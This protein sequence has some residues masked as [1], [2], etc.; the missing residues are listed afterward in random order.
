M[1]II[2]ASFGRTAT[3]STRIA[4]NHLGFG[5][6]YHMI[7]VFMHPSHIAQWQAAADGHPVDWREFLA[8]YP[9]GL[10]YPFSAFYKE[11]LAAFPEAKVILNVRDP[12][13][14][15]QSTRD[16]IY[17][18][19]LI[20]DWMNS[21]FIFHRGLKKMVDDTIW[22]RLFDGRFLER[23]YAIQVFNDHIKEVKALVPADRLLIFDVKEGWGPLCEFLNVPMPEKPFPHFNNRAMT[24]LGF[25]GVRIFGIFT[26]L[27]IPLLLIWAL[28]QIF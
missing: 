3:T 17:N 13:R 9:S 1:Q 28:S 12:Q 14:W 23:D 21:I 24:R 22:K 15:W 5:P 4:L 2:G 10:D 25:V 20:P 26:V 11:I 8:K 6:C 7:E 19:I 27:A 16:T 18:Q